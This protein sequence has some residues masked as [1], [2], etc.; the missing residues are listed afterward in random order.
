MTC[1]AVLGSR[2]SWTSARVVS[3][4]SALGSRWTHLNLRPT[5]S[6]RRMPHG[7]RLQR[8]LSPEEGSGVRRDH[9]P[10]GLRPSLERH[11]ETASPAGPR[12]STSLRWTGR[13]PQGHGD[14]HRPDEIERD[15][16]SANSIPGGTG[17]SRGSIAS[18]TR[19]RA[20]TTSRISRLRRPDRKAVRSCRSGHRP[21]VNAEGEPTDANFGN[22]EL[23]TRSGTFPL[24]RPRLPG[25][26]DCTTVRVF[27]DIYGGAR[28][29]MVTGNQRTAAL[30]RA[31]PGRREA[32]LGAR[33]DQHHG[34][35][36]EGQ[37]GV[38]RRWRQLCRCSRWS[39]LRRPGGR[40]RARR[41]AAAKARARSPPRQ[42]SSRRCCPGRCPISR[43]RSCRQPA[44]RDCA[45]LDDGL[46]NSGGRSSRPRVRSTHI[47]RMLD[48]MFAHTGTSTSIRRG[49]GA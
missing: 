14:Q 24:V 45:K 30:P 23:G 48:I 5:S 18:T 27:D 25:A 41:R 49:C 39:R 9:R 46:V 35:D 6:A 8:V 2:P 44:E 28:M 1:A 38:R 15:R 37:G 26:Y 42:A 7:P 17:T 43:P 16:G 33:A 11:A 13:L 3:E 31:W 10:Q 12:I 29:L 34:P 4:R 40:V 36:G 22:I 47:E 19:S 32:D 20:S 21:P